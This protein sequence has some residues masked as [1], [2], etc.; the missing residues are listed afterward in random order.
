MPKIRAIHPSFWNDTT[1]AECSTSARL[2]YIGL[3]TF[4]DDAGVFEYHERLI[5]SQ[6]FPFDNDINI[7]NLLKELIKHNR[8]KSF[9][10]N[11]R[12]YGLIINF[13]KYQKPDTRYV[14]YVIG[15]YEHVKSISHTVDTTIA[16]R[17]PPT[18]GVSVSVNEGVS[19]T[20]ADACSAKPKISKTYGNKNI[21]TIIEMFHVALGTNT[22]DGSVASNRYAATRL[23]KKVSKIVG[24]DEDGSI[25]HIRKAFDRGMADNFH[26][27]NLTRVS[28]LEKN[29]L[30][31]SNLIP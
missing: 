1:L 11:E 2:F 22:L 20:H 5:K 26:E 7:E 6:I 3:W 12:K 19:E 8:I 28:Y 24:C 16:R 25:E 21:N 15:D 14:R 29:F 13:T 31:L 23:M 9:I 27:K 4:A 10:H 18:E 17:A 30:K